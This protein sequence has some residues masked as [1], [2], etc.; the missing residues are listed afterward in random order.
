[1]NA[2]VQ[3]QRGGSLLEVLISVLILSIGLLG[4]VGMQTASLRNEQIS[5][6]RGLVADAMA[7]IAD[8]I[9]ANNAA[10]LPANAYAYSSAYATERANIDGSSTFLT[11]A[12]NCLTAVCTP[13]QLAAFDLAVWRANVDRQLPGGVGHVVA[14]GTREIDL[15]YVVTVAWA[16]NA[17]RA[18]GAGGTLASELAPRTCTAAMTGIAARTCC[19]AA[20]N[21]AGSPQIL[22]ARMEIVP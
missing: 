17:K 3:R 2:G 21:P 4:M 19:P 22:C 6:T 7:D 12:P 5:I 20:L 8:R 15:R 11:P 13:T 14:T 18:A 10:T 16:S 1:M 9:R